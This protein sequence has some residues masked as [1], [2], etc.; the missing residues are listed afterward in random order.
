MATKKKENL[1]V[2]V[3]H[4][5]SVK[6]KVAKAVIGTKQSIG[7]FYDEAALEKIKNDKT[8]PVSKD[9]PKY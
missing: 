9:H 8:S 5:P 6:N 4:A 7:G 3:K 1:T 2:M